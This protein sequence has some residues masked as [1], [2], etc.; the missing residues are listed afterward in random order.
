[1]SV[2]NVVIYLSCGPIHTME[3]SH[4]MQLQRRNERN[5]QSLL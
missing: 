4:L 2:T 1:M 3:I 5:E